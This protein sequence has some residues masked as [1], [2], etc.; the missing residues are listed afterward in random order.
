MA[1]VRPLSGFPELTPRDRVVEARILSTLR[2]VF[3][4]HG[5][6]E[7]ETRAVEPIERLAGDSEASKEIY[8]L[9]RLNADGDSDAKVGL[10]F[11]LTVPFARYVEENQGALQFPFRRWQMQKVWRG[12]RPQEGR[13]REFYQADIDIVAR[14]TLPEH[15][16]AEVAIVMARALRRLPIPSVTMHVNNRALVE[17]FYR[18]VGIDDVAG[19]LRS[20]DKLDKIGPDGVRAEL[21]A[22][23]VSETAADAALELARISSADSS[24]ASAV[25]DLWETTVKV[26]D[27]SGAQ[28]QL[29]RGIASL[30][31]LVDTVNAAVPGTAVADLRIAR[32]L[33]YYT[34]SV[35]ETFMDGHEAFGSICSGGRYDSLVAGGGF[36]GVGMSIG[37]S[38]LVA[39]LLSAGLASATRG[40]PSAVLVAVTE[41]ESRRASNAIADRLRARGIPCEVAPSASKFGKQI[42][43]ADRRGIPFVWFPAEDGD[44]QVKDIRSGDQVEA[45]A[46]I[47]APPAGDLWPE[48]VGSD[49]H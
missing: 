30:A 26:D 4:L 25:E 7:I 44:G 27:V 40:V 8:V 43:H 32:G 20:V 14:E 47:W 49:A 9:Q 16:E 41:E 29:A 13:F 10:H 1:R 38:R 35:Y 2:E 42:Q 12:E 48:V 28:D 36:P 22:Q 21:A 34:G 45:D 24:F 17:G 18:G 19:A 39:L 6:G 15:L 11:D 31:T 5:F 37:V 33:D 3:G 46:D 23:G